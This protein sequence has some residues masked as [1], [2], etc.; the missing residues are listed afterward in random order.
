[1]DYISR[2]ELIGSYEVAKIPLSSLKLESQEG[3]QR[4]VTSLPSLRDASQSEE[5]TLIRHQLWGLTIPEP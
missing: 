4:D 1:M 2:R 3:D 5:H